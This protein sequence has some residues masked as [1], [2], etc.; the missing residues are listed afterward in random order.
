MLY[1]ISH[2]LENRDIIEVRHTRLNITPFSANNSGE[3]ELVHIVLPS[4]HS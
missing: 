3:A 4:Y 2:E 1:T